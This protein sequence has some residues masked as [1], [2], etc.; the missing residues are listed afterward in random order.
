[1]NNKFLMY[2]KKEDEISKLLGDSR[3]SNL[4]RTTIEILYNR[5]FKSV[6]DIEHHLY[7][8]I[9]DVPPTLLLKDADI[10]VDRIKEAIKNNEKVVVKS[11]YDSDGVNGCIVAMK[12]FKRLGLNVSYFTNNRFV[13]GYGLKPVSIDRILELYPDVSLIVT[14]DNGITSNEAVEYANSKGIDVMITDHHEPGEKLPNALAVV[15]PKR[16]DCTYPFKGLCGTSVIFKLIMQL[17]FEFDILDESE[18]LLEFV[19]MGVVGD[20]VPI[21]NENRIFVKEGLKRIKSEENTTFKKLREALSLSVIDEETLGFTY[22]PMLNAPGRID[23]DASCGI[24]LF[25]TDDEKEQDILIKKLI[26]VNEY[27]KELTTKQENFGIEKVE[28]LDEIPPVI[29]VVND[30]F[31]EGVVG[32]VAGRLKEKYYRPTI[33]FA[34]N[35]KLDE[36]GNKI[37]EYKGSARSIEGFHIKKAFDKVSKY[38][39]GY[40]GHDMAGGLSVKVDELENFTKAINELAKNTLTEEDYIKKIY[41][42]TALDANEISID[43]IESLNILKPF[44]MGFIKP[45]FGL[46]NFFVDWELS[47]KNKYNKPYVG[48]DGKTLRLLND[49]NLTVMMFKY[50]QR[51][52]DLGEPYKLKA[53]GNPSLNVFNGYTSVQ[54]MVEEDFI[55]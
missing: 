52:K 37:V 4:N 14:V 46:K 7:S 15:N 9:D 49:N 39:I 5:G 6:E 30:N 17:Y 45:R 55:F 2:N 47:C 34:K 54:F 1:M 41:I 50:S 28:E 32:L 16:K 23:G 40:G 24:D 31:H 36:N 21:T 26:E 20:L 18:E 29:V 33:V 3:L 8:T 12:G 25:L 38:I 44:G 51:Y 11:D 42:D 22:C 13:E 10:F 35:E 19:A 27:R 43:L 48:E 53:I